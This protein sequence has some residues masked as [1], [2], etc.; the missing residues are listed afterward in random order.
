MAVDSLRSKGRAGVANEPFGARTLPVLA[1]GMALSLFLVISYLACVITYLIPGLPAGH[2]ML[3]ILLPDLKVL[4][5]SS[6]ILGLVESFICGWYVA[7]IFGP[8]YNYFILR[9]QLR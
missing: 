1:L 9:L 8:L 5:W 7:L 2:A 6:F 3:T 4:T